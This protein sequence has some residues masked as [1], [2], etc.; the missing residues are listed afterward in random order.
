MASRNDPTTWKPNHCQWSGCTG[1][2][3]HHGPVGGWLCR[4]HW[5][6][7][8]SAAAPRAEPVAG[9]PQP[10]LFDEAAA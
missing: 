2:A 6:A 5:L 4:A 7:Q 3:T 1:W 9:K 10:S 8:Q